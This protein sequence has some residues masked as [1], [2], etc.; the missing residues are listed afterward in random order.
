MREILGHFAGVELITASGGRE[1]IVLARSERPDAIL[2]DLHLADMRGEE[3][4]RE[5]KADPSTRYAPVI[6]VSADALPSR[7][8][9]AVEGGA[10]AYLTKPVDI[11]ALFTALESA[12]GADSV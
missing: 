5:V 1:G 2:L 7:M 11:A 8:A 10:A 4:L 9:A 6:V 3:V 12:L